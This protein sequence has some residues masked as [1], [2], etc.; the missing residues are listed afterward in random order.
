[1]VPASSATEFEV[2][3]KMEERTGLESARWRREEKLADLLVLL[4]PAKSM[5]N[6][7]G[8]NRKT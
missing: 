4:R 7:A 1:M 5:Q 6:G 2:K 3:R 8:F